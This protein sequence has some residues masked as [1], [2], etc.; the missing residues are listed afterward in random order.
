MKIFIFIIS[1]FLSLSTGFG[2]NVKFNSIIPRL[3]LLTFMDVLISPYDSSLMLTCGRDSKLWNIN[4]GRQLAHLPNVGNSKNN[5]IV[6]D[7][8]FVN[9]G[10]Y[11]IQSKSHVYEL[12]NIKTQ[13]LI[14]QLNN[15]GRKIYLIPHA[16][17]YI[18]KKL[19]HLLFRD[20]L[21][22][23][24]EDSLSLPRHCVMLD[25]VVK[26]GDFNGEIIKFIDS[27]R[28]IYQLDLSG[29]VI[30]QIKPNIH[31][32]FHISRWIPNTNFYIASV[33]RQRNY[34]YYLVDILGNKHIRLKYWRRYKKN[35]LLPVS[36]S[37]SDILQVDKDNHC[38]YRYH[39]D[40]DSFTVIEIPL[41]IKHESRLLSSTVFEINSENLVI[42]ETTKSEI[43]L[44]LINNRNHQFTDYRSINLD[45]VK[46]KLNG[47]QQIEVVEILENSGKIILLIKNNLNEC[48][49][50]INVFEENPTFIRWTMNNVFFDA[51]A[52][53]KSD[54]LLTSN[55][56]VYNW[57]LD[58]PLFIHKISSKDEIFN[59]DIEKAEIKSYSASN[60]TFKL[61][62]IVDS[63]SKHKFNNQT[64]WLRSDFQSLYSDSSFSFLLN[65]KYVFI[66]DNVKNRFIDSFRLQ[67]KN[68]TFDYI[69]LKAHS[70]SYTLVFTSSTKGH[71][72]AIQ[73]YTWDK[74][75]N[76]VKLQKLRLQNPVYWIKNTSFAFEI[77]NLGHRK[78]DFST[79]GLLK[80][81]DANEH[82][83]NQIRLLKLNTSDVI[84]LDTIVQSLDT[85]FNWKRN[86]LENVNLMELN[87][88]GKIIILGSSTFF[89]INPEDG[90]CTVNQWLSNFLKDS[91]FTVESAVINPL[92]R[93]QLLIG[94]WQGVVYLFDLNQN[95]LLNR[96][97][98]HSWLLRQCGWLND[99]TLYSLNPDELSIIS[100]KKDK[101][102]ARLNILGGNSLRIE[103]EDGYSYVSR[104][105]ARIMTYVDTSLNLL[106]FTSIDHLV[107]RPDKILNYFNKNISPNDDVFR[108]I[109]NRKAKKRLQKPIQLNS[110]DINTQLVPLSNLDYKQQLT[111][112]QVSKS[113]QKFDKIKVIINDVES[114]TKEV[115]NNVFIDT[116]YLNMGKNLISI[117]G[118]DNEQMEILLKSFEVVSTEKKYTPQV[119]FIGVGIN[120]YKS[121]RPNLNYCVRDVEDVSIALTNRYGENN[122]HKYI[123][124]DEQFDEP[125]KILD[126][127]EKISK[128]W[129]V[130]DLVVFWYSGHGLLNNSYQFFLTSSKTKDSSNHI[131]N[132]LS[133]DKVELLMGHIKCRK[134]IIFLDACN[135]GLTSSEIR[136][137]SNQYAQINLGV[138]GAGSGYVIKNENYDLEKINELFL[139]TTSNSG[140]VTL[141]AS[142]ASQKA[143]ELRSAENGLFTQSVVEVLQQNHN[144]KIPLSIFTHMVKEKMNQKTK[145]TT[146][147]QELSWRSELLNYDWEF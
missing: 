59:S 35:E 78:K 144:N 135:S 66:L 7:A 120:S 26:N 52:V 108:N 4:T 43:F 122:I 70:K 54:V 57:K 102:I 30:T 8:C 82:N 123:F 118:V 46:K 11:V 139:N 24:V 90:S 47:H 112:T 103:S 63:Y 133:Y 62:N 86:T 58:D 101:V 104:N 13:K 88:D 145:N 2:Q 73:C 134:K 25:E 92:N 140:V 116:L 36:E 6:I 119:Y 111:V 49:S 121:L 98:A 100:I 124:L 141:T 125:L 107:N 19:D 53:V 40:D 34:F 50:I 132:G 69:F 77:I 67:I 55:K 97:K 96:I 10:D 94:D 81:G 21:S 84:R 31:D 110:N 131:I 1:L 71:N 79:L 106:D 72:F 115:S 42:A 129:D 136:Y 38:Y 117:I 142:K 138:R 41:G 87:K 74:E 91:V 127:I 146:E 32:S 33:K 143:T 44:Y 83:S 61:R 85:S 28:T 3:E 95:K 16:D 12:W 23:S 147:K 15:S 14:W 64:T 89:T 114:N 48:I 109:V 39:L 75:Q 27:L 18:E 5:S 99:S 93:N 51:L 29:R 65:N 22:H 80:V 128:S 113:F 56:G 130:D 45:E 37:E 17:F 68:S 126:S 137:S 9:G 105:S 20:I 76:S 60:V